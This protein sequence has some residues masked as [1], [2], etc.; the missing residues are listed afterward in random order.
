MTTQQIS[1]VSFSP[2]G[3][4]KFLD[5][6]ESL[7]QEQ[8]LQ[9]INE[10]TSIEGTIHNP[11][12]LLRAIVMDEKTFGFVWEKP[13]AFIPFWEKIREELETGYFIGLDEYKPYPKDIKEAMHAT[14][15]EALKQ[16]EGIFLVLKSKPYLHF[17]TQCINAA[18]ENF[19]DN[20]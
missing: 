8:I 6:R 15:E 19:E 17:V 9:F 13:E 1:T 2:Y 3:I 20:Q 4:Q 7:T 16:K 12:K 10:V 18:R 14:G 5:S 11:T